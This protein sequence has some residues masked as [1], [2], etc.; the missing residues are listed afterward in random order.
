MRWALNSM[1]ASLIALALMAAIVTA[2]QS[3]HPSTDV[4]PASIPLA[5]QALSR[6]VIAEQ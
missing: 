3:L 5:Y 2:A 6:I 1:H 4:F